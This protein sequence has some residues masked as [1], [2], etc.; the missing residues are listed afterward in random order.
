M[1]DLFNLAAKRAL[2]MS[3]PSPQK[4]SIN[5]E[6]CQ[7]SEG[8]L[9]SIQKVMNIGGE[10]HKL[11]YINSDE[12][13]LLKA[14]GGQGEPMRGTNGIPA[15]AA[16]DPGN[17]GLADQ[18][19]TPKT[20][21]DTE[22][23]ETNL[24]NENERKILGRIFAEN[25]DFLKRIGEDSGKS[26]YT[27]EKEVPVSQDDIDFSEKTLAEPSLQ[28]PIDPAQLLDPTG[29]IRNR[30][31][32]RQTLATIFPD[33]TGPKTIHDL[34]L[35]QGTQRFEG[36]DLTPE[37]QKY[38]ES[39]GYN[40]Q[41]HPLVAD[42]GP[43]ITKDGKDIFGEV[44]QTDGEWGYRDWD[45]P[46][47][48]LFPVPGYEPGSSGSVKGQQIYNQLTEGYTG[49]VTQNDIEFKGLGGQ[50]YTKQF[51]DYAKQQGYEF[52]QTPGLEDA[53][54]TNF[55]PIGTPGG[56]EV[57]D[58]S[59]LPWTV[60]LT[61]LPSSMGDMR[62]D[63]GLERPMPHPWEKQGISEQ[64]W[65]E[66]WPGVD[67]EPLSPEDLLLYPEAPE[68]DRAVRARY[69]AWALINDPKPQSKTAPPP[70]VFADGSYGPAS[71]PE[72][73]R[74]GEPWIWEDVA[75]PAQPKEVYDPSTLPWTLPV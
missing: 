58:P 66:Q 69:A 59:T 50:G 62:T 16:V 67:Y 65:R 41:G 72:S 74:P 29:E 26:S 28:T 36:P 17:G 9:S 73:W 13:T 64:Q 14:I 32:P 31:G 42:A 2:Q 60:P 11:S 5:I 34:P 44:I 40:V 45:T 71:S 33:Y 52:R 54:G 38:I 46:E 10:P 27:E 15:Y 20:V 51:L 25:P 1:S 8:G 55:V 57:F 3:Q 61:E 21:E 47:N 22:G 53:P 48:P 30:L 4:I 39:Q 18:A 24:I 6:I 68:Q 12:S 43:L 70:P 63:P 56:Q 19:M 75:Q 35:P 23:E 7:P 49:P 37:F